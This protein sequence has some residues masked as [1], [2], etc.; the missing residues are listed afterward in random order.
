MTIYIKGDRALHH[1]GSSGSVTGEETMG[2]LLTQN[3]QYLLTQWIVELKKKKS[4]GDS[5]VSSL[6]NPIGGVIY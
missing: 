4:N 5:K 1:G 2:I 6:S 3:E